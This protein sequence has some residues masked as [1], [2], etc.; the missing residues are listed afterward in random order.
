MLQIVFFMIMYLGLHMY[1]I[2]SH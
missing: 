2:C 1:L